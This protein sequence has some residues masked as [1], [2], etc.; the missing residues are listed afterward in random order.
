MK[1]ISLVFLAILFVRCANNT[2]LDGYWHGSFKFDKDRVPA[3]IK[4]ENGKFIDLFSIFSDTIAYV[5]KGNQIHDINST[6]LYGIF[7]IEVNKNELTTIDSD[8]DSLIITLKKPEAA[9]F[10]F[11]YL[12]DKNLRIKLPIGKGIKRIVGQSSYFKNPLYLSYLNNE[13]VSNFLDTTVMVNS[14]YHILLRQKGN[15]SDRF[16]SSLHINRVSLIIDK[17][18]KMSDVNLIRKQLRLAGYSKVYYYLK[19]ESYEK[20]N[21]L[22]AR[23]NPITEL[24]YKK[25]NT[26]DNPLR[27]PPPPFT[28]NMFTGELLL[29]YIDRSNIKIN[30]KSYKLNQLTELI[31]S[32]QIPNKQIGFFY[33]ITN[34]STY[35]DFI[36]FNEVVTNAIYD[37][38]H[39]YLIKKYDIKYRDNFNLNSEEIRES[40]IRFPMILNQIDSLEYKK[41][42]SFKN[43][44][45][46]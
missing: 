37:L 31:K 17:N 25:Y 26:A 1:N 18:V 2:E 46:S 30:G 35:Q 38:R 14:K 24:D 27:P 15:Y 21:L 7:K 5:R 23:L 33:Y 45:K 3:L 13:L 4:F 28:I 41:I 40:H 8:A 34:N 43:S 39:D 22:S 6:T 32:K 42:K 12:N 29:I 16:E 44:K 20:V 9:N 10:I 19:S 36:S 11:D